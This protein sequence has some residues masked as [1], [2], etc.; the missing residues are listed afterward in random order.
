MKYGKIYITAAIFL[1]IGIIIFSAGFAMMGFN[2][3]NFDTE[4]AYIEKSY[5]LDGNV[6]SIIIEERDANINIVPSADKKI[7]IK[8]YE[9]GNKTY[10][11]GKLADGSLSIKKNATADFF[12]N[13]LTISVSTP[14]LTVEIPA[15]YDGK[16]V[17]ENQNGNTAAEDICMGSIKAEA[18]NGYIRIYKSRI[19]GNLDVDSENGNVE[20]YETVV[21]GKAKL[22]CENGRL[23]SQAVTAEEIYTETENGFMALVDTK[24]ESTI[25]AESENGN[26]ELSSIEFEAGATIISENGDIR[27]SVIGEESDF[28][29]NCVATNGNSN[30]KDMVSQGRKQLNL[31][32]ENGDIEISFLSASTPNE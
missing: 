7:N 19:T 15:N 11:I 5:S 23:F 18:E 26:I 29:Y 6:S 12:N 8:Y 3:M 21:G 1:F 27:G 10:T 31:R 30:L 14:I 20:L 24:A 2:I 4:P 22:S 9:N 17:I 32:S 13:F 16:M 28:S 25:F